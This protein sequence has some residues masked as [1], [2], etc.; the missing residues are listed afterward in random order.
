MFKEDILR[1]FQKSFNLSQ[2]QLVISNVY[3]Y[4]IGIAK[5]K[6]ETFSL[7][8]IPFLNKKDSNSRLAPTESAFEI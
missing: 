4:N 3:Q 5:M 6:W 7:N 2:S 8:L 1:D